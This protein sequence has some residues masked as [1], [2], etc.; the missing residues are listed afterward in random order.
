M[1]KAYCYPILFLSI[2][3]YR[4]HCQSFSKGQF[5]YIFYSRCCRTAVMSYN[6]GVKPIGFSLIMLI[7][8]EGRGIGV[9]LFVMSMPSYFSFVKT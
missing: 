3:Q 7:S 9:R 1:K 6:T 2:S 4:I 5:F 8:Y